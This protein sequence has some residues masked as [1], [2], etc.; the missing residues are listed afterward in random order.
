MLVVVFEAQASTR[1]ATGSSACEPISTTRAARSIAHKTESV[2]LVTIDGL[3]WQEVFGGAEESLLT[4]ENGGVRDVAGARKEFWRD[5]PEAR[6][7]ALMPFTW[8]VIAKDGQLFG[9]RTKESDVRVTNGKKFSY[10]GY[11]ELL[12]GA[13]DDRVDSND[14]K[15]NPNVSVLEWLNTRTGFRDRIAAF[16]SWDCF[17]FILNVERSKL[18]VNAGAM[19]VRDAP[20]DRQ[21]LVNDLIEQTTPPSEGVRHDSLTHYCAL[22]HLKSKHPRVLYVGYDQTDDFAHDGRYDLLLQ[23]ARQIDS[24]VRSLWETAQS[25]PEYHDKTTLLVTADHGRGDGPKEWRNHGAKTE[26][27]EFIWIAAIGPDTPAL[28][29]RAKTEPLTQS[30]IAA[31]LAALL[32][33]DYCAA[34]PAAGKPIADVVGTATLR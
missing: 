18:L 1:G 20:S 11:N 33:E 31:T 25:M 17:P 6:R 15:P 19:I 29:E 28:G 3:R 26:G 23:Q 16:C 13:P 10:P 2:I 32:G 7:A 12:T 27:A 24:F 4:K 22:E 30:Q 14:K 21:K 5:T 9:N 34:M 8:S